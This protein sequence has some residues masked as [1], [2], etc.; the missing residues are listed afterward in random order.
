MLCYFKKFIMDL[1]TLKKMSIYD[2][3]KLIRYKKSKYVSTV[4]RH[5]IFKY[6]NATTRVT[7]ATAIV[8]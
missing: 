4:N 2:K 1:Y 6:T 3:R 8:D 5:F 7:C